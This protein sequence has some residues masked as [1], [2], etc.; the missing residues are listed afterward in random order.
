MT[1]NLKKNNNIICATQKSPEWLS[2]SVT[3]LTMNFMTSI[4]WSQNKVQKVRMRLA[5]H[6][7]R[8]KEEAANILVL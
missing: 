2:I 8:Q 4:L 3:Q 5:G 1:Q 7:T 6:F